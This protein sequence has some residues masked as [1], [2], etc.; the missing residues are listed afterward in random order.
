[1]ISE[2]ERE[3]DRMTDKFRDHFNRG[4]GLTIGDTR[5]LSEHIRIM[6]EAIET[7]VL[8]PVFKEGVVGLM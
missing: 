6:K 7:N 1:M 5:P 3:F 4:Y 2:E 8:P